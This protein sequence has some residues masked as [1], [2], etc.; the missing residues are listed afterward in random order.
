MS[1]KLDILAL[2]K[3]NVFTYYNHGDY[4]SYYAHVGK[5]GQYGLVVRPLAGRPYPGAEWVRYNVRIYK[6]PHYVFHDVLRV[7]ENPYSP[8]TFFTTY[9]PQHFKNFYTSI[10]NNDKVPVV[11]EDHRLF[12][13]VCYEWKHPYN[14]YSKADV[15]RVGAVQVL[16][17]YL[18]KT[19]AI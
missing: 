16:L 14:P 1:E 11:F 2:L 13:T 18:S 10:C 8:E 19:H 15:I 7:G 6:G 4:E 5:D 9:R 12:D 17:E 3:Y